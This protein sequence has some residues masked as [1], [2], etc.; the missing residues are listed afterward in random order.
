MTQTYV[1]VST[2]AKLI[3]YHPMP[4][5]LKPHYFFHSSWVS[6]AAME[7]RPSVPANL[8]ARAAATILLLGG[9]PILRLGC[10]IHTT[11]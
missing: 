6:L 2:C 10:R 9:P 5:L 7:G 4:V 1:K 11:L 3:S 8:S